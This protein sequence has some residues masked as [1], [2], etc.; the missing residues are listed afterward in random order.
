MTVLENFEILRDGINQCK[1]MEMFENFF[2]EN[3]VMIQNGTTIE[4]KA[5]NREIQENFI[6]NSVIHEIKVISFE[7]Q[8]D[9]I[10]YQ[11]L[12]N[13]EIGGHVI[14]KNQ[15]VHQTWQNDKVIRELYV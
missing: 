5:K 12:M 2:D 6:K 14:N 1:F 7:E 9:T 13:F 8:G 3:V 15:E 10:V 11:M 4:G